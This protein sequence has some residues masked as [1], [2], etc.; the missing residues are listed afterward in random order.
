MNAV[1]NARTIKKFAKMTLRTVITLCDT[2]RRRDFR[3]RK[4]RGRAISKVSQSG[5]HY[6]IVRQNAAGAK[7]TKKVPRQRSGKPP[8]RRLI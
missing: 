8:R 6:H 4:E 7:N 5:D 2:P 1:N 3:Q